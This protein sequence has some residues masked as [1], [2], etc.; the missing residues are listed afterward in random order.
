[1]GETRSISPVSKG[2]APHCAHACDVSAQLAKAHLGYKTSPDWK[3]K[4]PWKERLCTVIGHGITG[5][6]IDGAA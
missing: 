2:E 1:M 5:T 3:E 4:E 6:G